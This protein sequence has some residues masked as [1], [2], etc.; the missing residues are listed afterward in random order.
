MGAEVANS[1]GWLLN[2]APRIAEAIENTPGAA[3]TLADIMAAFDLFHRRQGIDTKQKMSE[4][5]RNVSYDEQTDIVIVRQNF[6][7]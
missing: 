2:R 5:E 1:W 6:R 7:G 3:R 4:V